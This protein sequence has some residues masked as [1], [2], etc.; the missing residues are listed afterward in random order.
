MLRTFAVSN[1]RSTRDVK[2]SL[3]PLTVLGGANGSG[4]A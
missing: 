1:H 2:L 4:E 3:A